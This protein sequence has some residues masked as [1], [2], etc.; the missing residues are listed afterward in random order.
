MSELSKG[1]AGV[2]AALGA[3]TILGYGA[4]FYAFPILVPFVAAEFGVS[5]ATLFGMFSVGLFLGGVLSSRFGGWL[6]RFGAPRVMT[7]AS[8]AVAGLFAGLAAAPNIWVYGA[9]IVTLE[10]ISFLVLYDAAFAALA[11]R[12][13]RGTR[14]AITRLTLIGGFASTLF[15]PLTGWMVESIGW[16]GCYMVFAGLHLMVALPLHGW[17][18][19]LGRKMNLAAQSE[20]APAPDRAAVP[21]HHSKRAFWLLG[22]SFALTGIAIAAFGVHLVPVLLERGLGQ[23]AYLVGMAMGPTQVLVRVVDATLWRGFHPLSVALISGSAVALAV[24]VLLVPSSDMGLALAFAVLFGAGQGL[25]SIVRGAVPL[26]LFGPAGLGQR[27]GQLAGLRNVS[28]AAAPVL[29]AVAQQTIG[30]SATLW[31]C[32]VIALAGLALLIPLRK[33]AL[34]H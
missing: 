30:L 7:L 19:A 29:F 11:L 8:A 25:A 17:I 26:A 18:A 28:A 9:L 16:R 24:A 12:V 21:Q 13:P 14:Q 32:L 20:A 22:V 34:A 31:L 15:W 1:W 4:I 5:P 2:V 33:L 6:D 10:A 27:L 3:T 23:T